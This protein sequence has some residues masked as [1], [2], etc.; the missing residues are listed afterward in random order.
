MSAYSE[1][2]AKR[3]WAEQHIGKLKAALVEL[4]KT[5]P[6]SIMPKKNPQTGDVTYYVAHLPDIPL[7]I[8]LIIGDIVHNL[9]SALDYLASGLVSG[10]R[11]RSE[12]K[13]PIR[14]TSANDW[15]NSGLR[16]VGTASQEAKEAL[17]RLRPYEGGD[18]RFCV[19]QALNNIDKHRLLLTVCAKN[20]IQ[21]GLQ[22]GEVVGEQLEDIGTVLL[23]SGVYA[24]IVASNNIPAGPL[25]AGQEILTVRASHAKQQVG[26]GIEVAFGEPALAKGMPVE[27][28]IDWVKGG[29]D[30]AIRELA[31]FLL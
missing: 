1:A 14:S 18:P 12:A 23:S 20:T 5:D 8:P 31:P 30:R 11:N 4:R 28:T 3:E 16:M 19:L 6:C 7:A 10:P 22:G 17:R 13:F 2:L 26:F 15:E 27:F 24:R 9:R 29:V 25:Y 21:T